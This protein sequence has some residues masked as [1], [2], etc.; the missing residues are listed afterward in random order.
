MIK[1]ALRCGAGHAF[2]A[3]FR[4][5][6]AFEKQARRHLV[7]CPDCGGTDVDRQPMAPAVLKRGRAK[8]AEAAE[9]PSAPIQAAA[10][11]GTAP[12]LAALR[13]WRQHVL[14]NAEDVGGRFAD[15]A[16]KIHHGES[17]DRA[18]RGEASREDAAKLVEEGVAFGLLP[19]L[20]E[21]HN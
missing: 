18:I 1:Y 2:E 3:W 4:S 14:A 13:A 11:P 19:V 5:G 20:P 12:P 17:D 9:T 7:V 21:D 10:G 6:D 15:E 16:L 8:R